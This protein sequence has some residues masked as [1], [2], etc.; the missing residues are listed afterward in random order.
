V[1]EQER[2]FSNEIENDGILGDNGQEEE[3]KVEI[4]VEA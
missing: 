1:C 3:L 2:E 4:L